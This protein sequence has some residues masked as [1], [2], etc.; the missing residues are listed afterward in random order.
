MKEQTHDCLA[1]VRAALEKEYGPVELELAPT[2]V[3]ETGKTSAELNPLWFRYRDG[4]KKKRS[5]VSFN[6]CPF[7]GKK[8]VM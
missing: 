4:K 5:Y 6:Y 2:V 1:K 3:P 8:G 7:C